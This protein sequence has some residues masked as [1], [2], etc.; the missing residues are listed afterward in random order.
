MKDVM[1]GSLALSYK[2]WIRFWCGVCPSCRV[3]R[4][5]NRQAKSAILKARSVMS[6]RAPS[7]ALGRDRHQT[8]SK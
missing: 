4:R 7:A 5:T 2:G 1:C 3:K 8:A 6:P